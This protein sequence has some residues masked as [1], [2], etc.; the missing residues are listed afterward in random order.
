MMAAE[1]EERWTVQGVSTRS[2]G[3][4]EHVDAQKEA[5]RSGAARGGATRSAKLA[6][7]LPHALAAAASAS[8]PEGKVE[9]PGRTDG[10]VGLGES[11]GDRDSETALLGRE[12][13]ARSTVVDGTETR[14]DARCRP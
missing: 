6:G 2:A 12:V 5:R 4:V 13:S 1:D 9:G 14:G 8:S 7:V 3:A 11:L 10:G